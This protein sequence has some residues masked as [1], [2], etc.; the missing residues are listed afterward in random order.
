MFYLHDVRQYKHSVVEQSF[1]DCTL[2][3]KLPDI[4][5]SAV[6]W[7]YE[8]DAELFTLMCIVDHYG[9]IPTLYMPYLPHAR[10]DRVKASTDV[11]TLKTFAKA[12]N[13][14]GFD[15]VRMLDVHSNVGMA[16]I[17]HAEAMP[18]TLA[19]FHEWVID[20]VQERCDGAEPL[21]FFPD[22]GAMKRYSDSIGMKYAFGMKKRDWETGNI[23]G[24]DIINKELVRD[25]D[26]LIIDD[27][28]SRGG[29]FY[30]SA[31]ALKEAGAKS[32]FLAITHA[33][34]TMVSGGMYNEPGLIEHIFTTNSLFTLEDGREDKISVYD[35]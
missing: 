18:L 29:T 1:P 7:H 24:L 20:E 33:E 32:V 27:I 31:K 5:I 34:D 13:A 23:L 16:L 30:H 15:T 35:I 10:M 11:F 14:L 3:L 25:R 22:E 9:H 6:T 17:D 28:C 8:N 19:S 26:V 4:A 12:I 2:H 21:L